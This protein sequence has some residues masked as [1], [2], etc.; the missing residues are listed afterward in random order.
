MTYSDST[1][2]F[3][4]PVVAESGILQKTLG[5]EAIERT[6]THSFP[7]GKLTIRTRVLPTPKLFG[8]V[9]LYYTNPKGYRVV[10]DITPSYSWQ[11]NNAGTGYTR[12]SGTE[13]F[14][15]FSSGLLC[16][17]ELDDFI[18]TVKMIDDLIEVKMRGG[19]AMY[20]GVR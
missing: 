1:H 9:G 2:T 15:S 10:C 6:N 3:P 17:E 7:K 19:T 5:L 11:P 8:S 13:G 4:L 14:Y 18:N 12:T 16:R 20:G